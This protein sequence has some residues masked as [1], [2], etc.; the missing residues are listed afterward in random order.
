MA[1]QFADISWL[2]GFILLLA[3]FIG[4]VSKAFSKI[5]AWKIDIVKK[6]NE[7]STQLAYV[8][9][10]VRPNSGSTLYD[11]I[12]NISDEISLV[13]EDI[14]VQHHISRQIRD[15]MISIPY[16]EFDRDGNLIFANKKFQQAVGLGEH[17]LE[18]RG[19]ISI[20]PEGFRET[21]L[22]RYLKS[23][24]DKIPFQAT[25]DCLRCEEPFDTPHRYMLQTSNVIG[26]G[27]NVIYVTGK[28]T[29]IENT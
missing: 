19:W 16:C 29:K 2:V 24:V 22:S 8:F 13:R 4:L 15:D 23:I 20:F 27:R 28:I 1:E 5:I 12:N 7:A 11:K 18:Q 9:K 17:A 26:Y 21:I 3:T 14:M 10:E 6:F 25:F